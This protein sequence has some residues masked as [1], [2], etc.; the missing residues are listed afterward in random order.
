MMALSGMELFKNW[1]QT[2][3]D[4]GFVSGS[5]R[6]L[7]AFIARA[8]H[9]RSLAPTEITTSNDIDLEHMFPESLEATHTE[10]VVESQITDTN[11]SIEISNELASEK[12][13]NP[14]LTFEK[15]NNSSEELVESAIID[16][17]VSIEV[18]N[19]PVTD[20]DLI[21]EI[22]ADKI[23]ES[24]ESG[25]ID[26]NVMQDGPMVDSE[27]LL[28]ALKSSYEHESDDVDYGS[29][30]IDVLLPEAAGYMA[31]IESSIESVLINNGSQDTL[32]AMFRAV[33]GLKGALRTAGANKAGA[34]LHMLEDDLSLIQIAQINHP[35][36]AVYQFA[37]DLVTETISRIEFERNKNN[38][39][40][41]SEVITAQPSSIHVDIESV[42]ED[43][44]P[45]D[46]Q[47]LNID[48]INVVTSAEKHSNISPMA[49]DTSFEPKINPTSVISNGPISVSGDA[50]NRI[51]RRTGE[52]VALQGRAVEEIEIAFKCVK[53]L[54][55][56]IDRLSDQMKDLLL[57]SQINVDTGRKSDVSLAG[58]DTLEI[59]RYTALQELVRMMSENVEDIKASE[60]ELM[61]ALSSLSQTQEEKES[62]SNEILREANQL[63]VVSLST[64][65]NK[66][67]STVRL[68]SRETGKSVELEF[69]G[70]AEVP[71]AVMSKLTTAIDH[72]LRNA[73]A[74][75]IETP[76]RRA[77]ERKPRTGKI[78]INVTS[79]TEKTVIII[80]DDGAGMNKHRILEKARENGMASVRDYSDQEI[81]DL[82]F[83][84][85]LSTAESVSELAG[86]GVGLDAVKSAL[87]E[88]GGEIFVTSVLGKGTEFRIEAPTDVTTLS[89]IKVS[90][91]GY[92]SLIPASL[93]ERIVPIPSSEANEAAKDGFITISGQ[94]FRFMR[95]GWLV[96][97][98]TTPNRKPYTQLILCGSSAG[99]P[100]AFEVDDTSVGRKVLVRPLG[101]GI[102]NIPGLIAGTTL[103]DGSVSII[104]NPLRMRLI[105]KDVDILD[106]RPAL[107]LIMVVDD[108]PTVRMYTSKFLQ[109]HGYEVI[110]AS[111]GIDAL[112]VLKNF[113]PDIFLLD[114]EM[115]RMGGFE[116]VSSIK[117]IERLSNIPIAMI[118]S[119][120]SQKHRDHAL[121]LGVNDYIGKPFEENELLRVLD[122]RNLL[123]IK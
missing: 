101:R 100:T 45:L 122:K 48:N 40:L 3:K 46:D 37:F 15:I 30:L 19:A 113:T 103:S 74:H 8:S 12:T 96:S 9:C 116:L 115:P 43:D 104:V 65:K 53:T 83:M 59:D 29:G 86:R 73:V 26:F 25:D 112:E 64:R 89:V 18:L 4:T 78:S 93:V 44:S 95:M 10:H 33:H 118:T 110:E 98:E 17:N 61:V 24:S 42:P 28:L 1:L 92:T 55:L 77:A 21:P 68:A 108:S 76:E 14:E 52:S 20:T 67:Q 121:S 5:Y 119:R 13:L 22:V 63:M 105:G 50:L 23:N 32:D 107:P 16:A 57:H 56:N 31:D 49:N 99:V 97:E 70:D 71:S 111:D 11:I 120:T 39:T 66:M 90:A 34:V 87:A 80:K 51:G 58:F 91:Q 114:V 27:S 36:A 47:L 6:E 69:S 106:S 38:Q 7:N 54:A 84:R 62:I 72:I 81:F 41:A 35:R 82:I 109:K 94:K 79:G 85:G 102:A 60:A 123:T 75:G 2:L 117:A 88:V